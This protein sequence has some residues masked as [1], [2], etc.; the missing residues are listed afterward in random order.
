[1]AVLL[2]SE[3]NVLQCNPRITSLTVL[4]YR[5]FPVT[6]AW[7]TTEQNATFSSNFVIMLD[8]NMP[9]V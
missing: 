4:S 2:T 7:I 1:M 8:E 3:M 6:I 5:D 9:N